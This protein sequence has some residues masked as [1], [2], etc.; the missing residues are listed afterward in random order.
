MKYTEIKNI[1]SQIQDPVERLEFVMDLGRQLSPIPAGQTGTEIKGC[2]SLVEIFQDSTGKYF[3]AADSALVRGI[4]Y[5][6]LA[7]AT[8]K[9][10][11]LTAEFESLNL[12]L[13]TGRMTGVAGIIEY[14]VS[15]I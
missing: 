5:I 10:S 14:L 11:D 12:N 1:L 6:I 2:A 15:S 4:V 8:D 3:A 13:G 9:V 7:M